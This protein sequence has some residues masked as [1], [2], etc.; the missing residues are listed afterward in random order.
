M[1]KYV[2][3]APVEQLREEVMPLE[4]GLPAMVAAQHSLHQMLHNY[5][6]GHFFSIEQPKP[7]KGGKSAVEEKYRDVNK[8][9]V[10]KKESLMAIGF[11]D[12]GGLHGLGV[13]INRRDQS[14]IEAGYY[15]GGQL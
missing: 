15:V 2:R 13:I 14:V 6:E 7:K 12:Q 5:R 3:G 1:I 11:R 10:N 4:M 8:A 9:M